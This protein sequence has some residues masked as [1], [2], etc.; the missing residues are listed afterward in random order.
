MSKKLIS[1]LLVVTLMVSCISPTIFALQPN[2]AQVTAASLSEAELEKLNNAMHVVKN[3]V[4]ETQNVFLDPK[5]AEAITTIFDDVMK[6]ASATGTIFTAVNGSITFMKLVGLIKD[7]NSEA[8]ANIQHQLQ[9]IN[10]QLEMTEM[11]LSNITTQMSQIQASAEFN[12]RTEKAIMLQERWNDFSYRNMEDGLDNLMTQYNGMLLNGMQ[13]WCLNKTEDARTKDGTDNARILLH[14]EKIG[15]EYRLKYTTENEEPSDFSPADRYLE[16]SPDFLPAKLTWNVNN[17]RAAIESFISQKIRETE[18]FSVFACGN[19]PAFTEEGAEELTDELIA[20]VAE[21]AVNVLLY[22]VTAAEVNKDATFSL[23]VVRQFSNY[24]KY[25]VSSEDGMSTLFQV[26]YLTHAFE[27]QIADSLKLFCNEMSIKTGVYG[28]FVTNVLSMSSFVT[29]SQKASQLEDYCNTLITIGNM[30]ENCLTGHDNY[31]YLTNTELYLGDVT[32][33]DRVSANTREITVRHA[34]ESYS[35][36]PTK[37]DYHGNWSS[38]SSPALLGDSNALLLTYM[39]M[40]NGEKPDFAYLKEVLDSDVRDYGAI[41]TSL[42][43]VQLLPM[44]STVG[45]EVINVIGSYFRTGST[46]SLRNL[47]NDA[48]SDYIRYRSMVSGSVL[49]K[50][51]GLEVNK[52]LDAVAFY[53]EDHWYWEKDEAAFL[54]GAE[55]PGKITKS[56]EKIKTDTGFPP[57]TYYYR[58]DYKQSVSYNCLVSIPLE[59]LSINSTPLYTYTVLCNQIKEDCASPSFVDVPTDAY[60]FDSVLW[61][62]EN[63]ITT[64]TNETHFSPGGTCT[65]AQLVSF[66]WRAAGKPM[67]EELHCAFTDVDLDAYYGQAL[68]WAVEQGITT[69]ISDTTFNPNGIVSRSQMVTFLYRFAGG[70]AADVALPFDD[71]SRDSYYYD[72]VAWAFDNE[73]TTGTKAKTFSPAAD[74]SRA[75]AVTFLH[76]LMAG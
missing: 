30:K 2:D 68:L 16:L 51:S 22:R 18:D 71:V 74:C 61:A 75:Q 34:Y 55:Y 3:S 72:A 12:T 54:G 69:G 6:V 20:Q 7:E 52:V 60:Y 48:D 38:T 76:R 13:N 66:L 23:Q 53:A 19:F 8:L 47:P 24:C 37:I 32:F 11:Q 21:D 67:P 70:A 45:L 17:Y 28:S 14:Y 33:T 65:R 40:S 56:A 64:G 39:L 4:S 42:N 63:E 57:G 50:A 31:C 62:Y 49:N 41:V 43:G 27:F 44:S 9:V 26:F 15:G 73:L 46:T 36:T 5:T 25:L 35:S 29:D 59:T 58:T 1:L 10:E